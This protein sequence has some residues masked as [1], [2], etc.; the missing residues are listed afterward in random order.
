MP[1]P[2]GAARRMRWIGAWALGLLSLSACGDSVPDARPPS[3]SGAL[4]KTAPDVLVI[5]VPQLSA[6]IL[7]QPALVG[8]AERG[9]GFWLAQGVAFDAAYA[10]FDQPQLNHA[11]ALS[12]GAG[13]ARPVEALGDPESHWVAALQAGSYRVDTGPWRSAEQE[14]EE[15]TQEADGPRARFV[16]LGTSE[17]SDIEAVLVAAQA[18]W[19]NAGERPR[20][21]VF[22]ALQ[23]E[24]EAEPMSEAALRVPLWFAATEGIDGGERRPIVVTLADV[25]PTVLDLCGVWPEGQQRGDLEGESFARVLIKEPI[26]WRGFGLA[27][28]SDG[29]AWVRSARWRLIRFG[30]GR[31]LLSQVD[32]DPRRMDDDRTVPGAVAQFR[33]L[34]L[35]LDAWLASR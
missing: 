24:A 35:R 20:L 29:S 34:G 19:A 6:S 13:G 4:A 30:D 26:A 12:M 15:F 10:R 33:G 18:L 16:E 5:E 2:V 3:P 27:L 21:V 32:T 1:K 11:D 8:D 17:W 31:E 22:Y 14:L 25:G 9:L 7:D 28:V 23:G